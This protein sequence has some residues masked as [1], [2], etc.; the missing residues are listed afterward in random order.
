MRSADP[1]RRTSASATSATTSTDRTL[2]CLK[3]VPDRP[4]LSLSAMFRSVRDPCSAGIR[5]NRRPVASETT[6]VNASTRQST[7][8]SDPFSP[9]RGIPAVLMDNRARI[10]ATPSTMPSAPPATDSRTLSVSSCLMIRPRPAPIAERIAISRRR[11]VARTSS[12]FATLA[13]AMSRT[14]TTATLMTSR[15][16][17]TLLTNAS[18]NGATEKPPFGP[19]APGNLVLYSSADSFSRACAWAS[20]TPGLRRAAAWK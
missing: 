14:K 8:T 19:R 3:P 15:I 6:T 10:P 5:P 16:G 7:P 2:F 12:R 20:S 4:P 13:Q 11:A 17:R 1:I 18:R 9:R